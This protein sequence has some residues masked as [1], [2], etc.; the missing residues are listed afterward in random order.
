MKDMGF[1]EKVRIQPIEPEDDG[2]MAGIIREN[3][4]KFGLDIPGTAY[5]DPELDHLS[6]Y[7]GVPSA[8]RAYFIA[9][10]PK[11]SVLGGAGMAAFP[12]YS[13]CAELQKLYVSEN[14][15]GRG[16]GRYLLEAVEAYARRAGYERLYLEP[17]RNLTTAICLYEKWDMKGAIRPR[18]QSIAP[19]IL[20]IEKSCRK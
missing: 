10:D 1:L 20:S 2:A 4:E 7:Y 16:L 6:T 19:W 11:G 8:G 14:V 18:R 5:F 17:H 12:G 3:L 13:S 15:K 9:K